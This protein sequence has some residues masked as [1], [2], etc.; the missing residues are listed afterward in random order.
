ME[1]FNFVLLGSDENVYGFARSIYNNYK[2]KP[3]A[4]THHILSVTKNTKIINYVVNNKVHDEE[5]F[6]YAL[7]KLTSKLIKKYDKLIL[8]PCSD[9]YMELVV[10]NQKRI[11][12]ICNNF[13]NYKR[14]E[15]FN[16]KEKFYKICDKYGIEYPKSYMIYKDSYKKEIKKL[17]I[18]YPVILKPNNSNSEEYL[19]AKFKNKN[20][21]YL[22][23]NYDELEETINNIYSSTYKDSLIIQKY[24]P[25]DDTNMR[26]LNVYC[27]KDSKVKLMSLGRPI[28]EEYHPNT[29]G[30]YAAIISLRDYLPVM[31]KIKKFLEDVKYYG[32]AN[33]DI[34]YNKDDHKY[35]VFE[36][37]PRPGRSSY[38][39]ACAGKSLTSCYVEDL[40]Y[41]N[42][43]KHIRNDKEVLWLNVPMILVRKYVK[44]KK[45][46]K[47]IRGLKRY[48]TL[49]YKKDLSFK[50]I[51]TIFG[52]YI[53]KI[54]YFPKY[55]IEKR[56]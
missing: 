49:I 54:K 14:F 55:Y 7:N 35:Y 2:I 15:E 43:K 51:K 48:H 20:K 19:N 29:Y 40:I 5:E 13:I 44:D 23:N 39:S 52:T 34:K 9:Y 17:D 46:L 6:V 11:K 26:V 30:N 47:K 16:N 25:G 4:L 24:I 32:V 1:K 12:N 38:F 3:Y 53:K 18:S 33:F 8:V 42:I 27:D 56:G 41:G 22:I 21:V 28:L 37:N 10:K 50:R 36:I 45:I 31:D